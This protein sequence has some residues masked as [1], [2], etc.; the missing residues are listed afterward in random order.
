VGGRCSPRAWV[1]IRSE[2]IPALAAATEAAGAWVCPTLAIAHRLG[3]TL[4]GNERDASRANR[5]AVVRALQRAG[6][7][8]LV[9]SDAGIDVVDPGASLHD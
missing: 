5:G 8:L 9:G 7:G 1:R 2:R 6:A 3:R 4:P